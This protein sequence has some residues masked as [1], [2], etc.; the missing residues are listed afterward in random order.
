MIEVLKIYRAYLIFAA[1]VILAVLASV[2]IAESELQKDQLEVPDGIIYVYSDL[3]PYCKKFEPKFEQVVYSLPKLEVTRWN[4]REDIYLQTKA[5]R[6][7]VEAT[8]TVLV[9]K[10][11]KVVDSLVG[12]REEH[13]LRRFILNNFDEE[14]L[15][16]S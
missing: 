14:S 7:G 9:V 3:C 15:I 13:E 12:D 10:E 4:I 1:V 8:P 2:A 11:G 5:S 16:D 6:L